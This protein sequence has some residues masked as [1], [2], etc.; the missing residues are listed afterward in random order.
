[1][2]EVAVL[3]G[4]G[5][6]ADAGLPT[7]V[8]LTKD[9][10]DHVATRGRPEV[11]RV[12]NFVAGQ[13]LSHE[14]VQGHSP[15]A[16]LDVERLMTAIELLADRRTLELSAFVYAWH[17][18]V[19]AI[20][21]EEGSGFGS[22]RLAEDIKR[23]LVSDFDHQLIEPLQRLIRTTVG[24][25]GSG[26]TYQTA[27]SVLRSALTSILQEHGDTSYLEPIFELCQPW[28]VVASL[29]YDLTV[30]SA[31]ERVGVSLT[32]GVE[33][34]STSGEWRWPDTGVRLL[35]LH[36]SIDWRESSRPL[37]EGLLPQL[38]IDVGG[39]RE[40]PAV[41]FGGRNKLRPDG[42]FLELLA[43]FELMLAEARALVVVGYSFRDEHVNE[44]LRR[45]LNAR[46]ENRLV[47]L[48]PSLG[49]ER[50]GSF[51]LAKSGDWTSFSSQLEQ[52]LRGRPLRTAITTGPHQR[53]ELPEIPARIRFIHDTAKAGLPEAISVAM[54]QDPW[55]PEGP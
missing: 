31:A 12:V 34:W 38:R 54:S 10:A 8:G 55:S 4:A 36:G 24:V 20:E 2:S 51:G 6:S 53:D 41:I 40:T 42:P 37:E 44:V 23:G 17:P 50:C 39:S 25:G 52:H 3:L 30:E 27:F 14:G 48:D 43:Q 47:I 26:N 49:Q 28:L 33:E 11:T 45:W 13:L 32:T 29:N 7:T 1:M 22:N 21:S 46:R 18:T 5:A 19:A 16:A 35:K 9:L 15:F